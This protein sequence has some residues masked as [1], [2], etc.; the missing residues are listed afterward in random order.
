VSE[1]GKLKE[2]VLMT[3]KGD[4]RKRRDQSRVTFQSCYRVEVM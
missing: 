4:G 3:W 2:D 1:V